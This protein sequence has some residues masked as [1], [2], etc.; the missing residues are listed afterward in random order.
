MKHNPALDEKL[1]LAHWEASTTAIDTAFVREHGY[2]QA[3]VERLERSIAL[4]EKAFGLDSSLSPDDVYAD[5][6]M[7]R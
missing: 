4:V 7:P 2:G 6:F 5:G 3:T 1:M